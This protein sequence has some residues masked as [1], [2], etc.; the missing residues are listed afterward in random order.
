MRTCMQAEWLR[1]QEQRVHDLES[2][3]ALVTVARNRTWQQKI[4][5]G[6]KIKQ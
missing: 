3:A 2:C 1:I 5:Q 6:G 4:L